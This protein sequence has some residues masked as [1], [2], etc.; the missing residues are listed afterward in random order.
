VRLALTLTSTLLL[1]AACARKDAAPAADSAAAATPARVSSIEGFKTPESAL[2]DAEQQVW[3]VSNINGSPVAKDGNGYISRLDRDGAVEQPQ[4]VAGGQGNVVLNAPKGL[5]IVG[6][7]LWV[8]DID[9]LRGFNRRSGAAV[10]TVE[11]GAQAKFLNDVAVGPDGTIYITDTGAGMDDKGNFT[12]PGPDRVFAVAGR[13]VT[14]ALEGAWLTQPNGIT[15][16][17]ANGRFVLAPFGGPAITGWRPGEKTVDTLGT[18]PGGFDGV[19]VLGGEIYVTSWADSSLYAL[20]AGGLR[21]VATGLNS[22][23]DIGLDPTRDLV[24]IPL[25]MENRVEVW[26]MR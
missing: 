25:F 16:D 4:F 14:V 9:A 5:A 1:G 2:W 12:H 24:A 20:G 8:A 21:K 15:W 3:F 26:R 11:F 10:A 7:T 6:D 23:A 18:G 17:P 13:Q 22:P 19:E